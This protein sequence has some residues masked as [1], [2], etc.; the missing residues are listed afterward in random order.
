MDNL[1]LPIT[2]DQGA[3]FYLPITYKD[4]DGDPIIITDYSA[5]MQ[6]RETL[7]SDDTLVDLST[8]TGEI[9]ITGVDGLIV[10]TIGTT[11]TALLPAGMRGVWDL[12]I[13]SPFNIVTRL[14]GGEAYVVGRVTRES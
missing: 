7:N 2:I 5:R 14:L 10:I 6:I 11:V 13:T 1:N 8:E 4:E 3:T 9:V 12:F